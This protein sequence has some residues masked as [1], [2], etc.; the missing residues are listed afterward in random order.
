M[1]A[2]QQYEGHNKKRGA[3]SR[4]GEVAPRSFVLQEW[5]TYVRL[6][7]SDKGR[8]PPPFCLGCSTG[9][10]FSQQTQRGRDVIP[11]PLRLCYNVRVI[12]S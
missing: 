6:I 8:Q 11:A 3:A 5:H 4:S 2:V 1:P 12:Q 7:D 10:G 9:R